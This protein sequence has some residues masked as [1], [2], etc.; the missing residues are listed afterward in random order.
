V[1]GGAGGDGLKEE[2]GGGGVKEEWDGGNVAM[3]RRGRV[4]RLSRDPSHDSLT[5]VGSHPL[6]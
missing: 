1:I 2:G 3:P 6:C 4:I 5:L